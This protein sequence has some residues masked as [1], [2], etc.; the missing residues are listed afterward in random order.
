[1]NRPKVVGAIFSV[2]LAVG[3]VST[4]SW[5]DEV[6]Q[7]QGEWTDLQW[8][9]QRETTDEIDRLVA[10][11]R[12]AIELDS[13]VEEES[14]PSGEFGKDYVLVAIVESEGSYALLRPKHSKV[15]GEVVR[16]NVGDRLKDEWKIHQITDVAVV[17]TKQEETQSVELFSEL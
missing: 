9:G 2:S 6:V 11:G 8:S 10:S 7:N 12:W 15:I 5:R 13:K 4:I 17:A 16:V 3:I 14:G 1:M